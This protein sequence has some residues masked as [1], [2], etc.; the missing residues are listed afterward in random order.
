ML[1]YWSFYWEVCDYH[2]FLQIAE[3]KAKRD[4]NQEQEK[5]KKAR[6]E[7]LEKTVKHQQ[8]E[9]KKRASQVAEF[10][11]VIVAP[12]ISVVPSKNQ[13]SKQKHAAGAKRGKHYDV[14]GAK[15]GK[16]AAAS[17]RQAR[18]NDRTPSHDWV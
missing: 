12:Q 7:H 9:L 15:R 16:H 18:E 4:Q 10:E 14:T 1:S 6:I 2:F 11:R 17:R 5:Q 13:T 8:Q 3:L